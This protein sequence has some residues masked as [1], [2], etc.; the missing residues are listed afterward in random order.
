MPTPP[1]IGLWHASMAGIRASTPDLRHR[2]PQMG[3]SASKI[4]EAE[5]KSEAQAKSREA[6]LQSETAVDASPLGQSGDTTRSLVFRPKDE[7]EAGGIE[8]LKLDASHPTP[9]P[10]PAL[11][12]IPP[13][14]T[15][16]IAPAL[17]A[18]H[19]HP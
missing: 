12:L 9:P 15:P 7:I 17:A 19:I 4:A 13:P 8:D 3:R 11:S 5:A 1:S 16:P 14:T 10:W 6:S 2:A 18:F